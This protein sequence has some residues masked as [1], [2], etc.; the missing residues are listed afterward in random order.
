MAIYALGDL[1]PTIAPS[2]YVHPDATVIGDVTIGEESS[3]WPHAV[4]R[5]DYGTIVIGRRTNVQ[6]GA[7]VHA[8]ARVETVI[9]DGVVIGHLAHLEGCTV[10]DGV[11]VGSGSIV[12]HHVVVGDGAI[13]GAA[14]FVPNRMQIPPGAMALGVPA[15]IR[16][17]AAPAGHATGAAAGYAANAARYRT[18]LRRIG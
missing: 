7:V 14:A 3:V 18:G 10:G 17:G 1:E 4:V 15:R 11:L 13:V 6:D 9:G 12:L 8:T 5:G 2:A 16:E